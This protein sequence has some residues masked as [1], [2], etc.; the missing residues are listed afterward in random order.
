[1]SN[2]R[3]IALLV[4]ATLVVLSVI[5]AIII[6]PKLHNRVILQEVFEQ[7]ATIL[8]APKKRH[9]K[10]TEYV[11]WKRNPFSPFKVSVRTRSVLELNGIMWDVKKPQ[12]IINNRIVEI[13]D[14]VAGNTVVD[15][16]EDK[17][18]LNNG[19]DDF[20]LRLGR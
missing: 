16:G 4:I 10:K 19:L 20:E 9:A 5:R 8:I 2:K 13:G 18:I 17:V 7:E 11:F 6:R 15:I 3:T 1:M 14:S 12:A